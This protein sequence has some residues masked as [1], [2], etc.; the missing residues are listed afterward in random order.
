MANL[1]RWSGADLRSDV[2]L[3]HMTCM[4]LSKIINTPPHQSRPFLMQFQI[5]YLTKYNYSGCIDNDND[6]DN[7]NFIIVT[8]V[9]IKTK[10]NRTIQ[11]NL[12]IHDYSNHLYQIKKSLSPNNPSTS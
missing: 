8:L 6:N 9:K 5:L 3:T 10:I 1:I 11:E 2:T 4:T 12:A 7:D